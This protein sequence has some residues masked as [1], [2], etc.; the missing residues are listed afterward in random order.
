MTPSFC[1]EIDVTTELI[2]EDLSCQNEQRV[3]GK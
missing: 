2:L 3:Q 1:L